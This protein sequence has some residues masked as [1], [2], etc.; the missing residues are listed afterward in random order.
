MENM[1]SQQAIYYWQ[2]RLPVMG[3]IHLSYWPRNSPGNFLTTHTVVKTNV[4]SPQTA[5]GSQCGEQYPH[6]LCTWRIWPDASM[7]S[8]PLPYVLVSLVWKGT[9]QA[10]KRGLW[11]TTKPQN[12]WLTITPACKM[13]K[14]NGVTEL[15]AISNKYLIWLKE[16][17][18]ETLWITNN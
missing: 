10:T 18:L 9:I 7:L 5:S 17:I 16:N 4:C 11:K 8:L 12:L 3:C 2:P 15:V 6:I 14:G 13:Y 1:K